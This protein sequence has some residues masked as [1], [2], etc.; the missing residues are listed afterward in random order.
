MKYFP[1]NI[2]HHSAMMERYEFSSSK[3]TDLH[4]QEPSLSDISIVFQ[5]FNEC[6]VDKKYI[7]ENA[8]DSDQW[9]FSSAMADLVMFEKIFSSINIHSK[10]LY[11]YI[12]TNAGGHHADNIEYGIYCP[13]NYLIYIVSLLNE[14]YS[15]PNIL[16]L[17]LDHH[18]GDGDYKIFKKYQAFMGTSNNLSGISMHGDW[19]DIDESNYLGISYG[20]DICDDNFINK[21]N[22]GFDKIYSGQEIILLFQG[23]DIIPGDYGHIKSISDEIFMKI[24]NLVKSKVNPYTRIYVF[25]LGGMLKENYQNLFESYIKT[26]ENNN[27]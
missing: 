6:F 8:L 15:F 1:Y 13:Y 10:D 24:F 11:N 7:G 9:K 4:F 2:K 20:L 5:R 17:D 25:Q 14:I 19:I 27:Q 26:F 22:I 18:F 21:L 12:F 3:T 23:S 16:W